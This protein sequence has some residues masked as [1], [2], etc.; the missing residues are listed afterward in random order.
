MP[1]HTGKYEATYISVCRLH[2]YRAISK[3]NGDGDGDGNTMPTQA[4]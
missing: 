4:V 1:V 2:M 3:G